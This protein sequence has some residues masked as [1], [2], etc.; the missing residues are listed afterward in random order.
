MQNWIVKLI[1]SFWYK[2][3]ELYSSDIITFIILF[4]LDITNV[5]F[6]CGK[7]EDV[8]PNILK[9]FAN[10]KVVA[11]VDPPRAGLRKLHFI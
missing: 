6:H 7:A 10:E 1:V 3:K 4:V 11:I 5:E 8:L 9:R 2:F